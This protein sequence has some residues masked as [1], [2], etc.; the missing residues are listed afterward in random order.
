MEGS[1]W[2]AFS[3]SCADSC[4]GIHRGDRDMAQKEEQMCPNRRNYRRE[5]RERESE[6]RKGEGT[7]A[8]RNMDGEPDESRERENDASKDT[9]AD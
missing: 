8:I 9:R 6:E 2:I 3:S 7:V 4:I 5:K 1:Q